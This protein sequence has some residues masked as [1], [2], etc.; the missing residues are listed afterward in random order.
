MLLYNNRKIGNRPTYVSNWRLS[1]IQ[2]FKT[3]NE[4]VVFVHQV[5]LSNKIY[6]VEVTYKRLQFSNEDFYKQVIYNPRTS[7]W[8]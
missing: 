7:Y 8:K 6:N 1:M 4:T 3:W 2:W 5:K